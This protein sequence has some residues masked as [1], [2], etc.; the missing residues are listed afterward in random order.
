MLLADPFRVVID[1]P[2]L[3]WDNPSTLTSGLVEGLR[4]R[5]IQARNITNRA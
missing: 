3:K 5:I 2:E 1:L 4:Q